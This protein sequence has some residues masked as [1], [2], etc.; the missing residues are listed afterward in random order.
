MQN[1]FSFSN[2][3][4]VPTSNNKIS[5]GYIKEICAKTKKYRIEAGFDDLTEFCKLLKINPS[6]YIEYEDI[7]PIPQYLIPDFCRLTKIHPWLLLSNKPVPGFLK[8]K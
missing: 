4:I 8:L 5:A 2:G 1:I 6:Y 7:T 3:E